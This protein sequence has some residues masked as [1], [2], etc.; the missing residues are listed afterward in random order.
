MTKQIKD[1][2]L[3]ISWETYNYELLRD[4]RLIRP[5]MIFGV[6]FFLF[7]VLGV[8][9]AFN[10]FNAFVLFSGIVI[11][12]LGWNMRGIKNK[13]DLREDSKLVK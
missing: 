11:F 6:L 13:N 1:P 5:F 8:V 9:F 10:V 12:Y 4:Y 3:Q 2:D 7:G